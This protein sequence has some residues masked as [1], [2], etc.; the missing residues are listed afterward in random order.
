MSKKL[1]LLVAALF[2]FGC[3]AWAAE[4]NWTGV[5]S[6]DHCQAKHATASDAAA[7]CVAKCVSGG[8]KYVLVVGKKILKVDPQDKFADFAGKRVKVT[9]TLSGDT[10]TATNVEAAAAAMKAAGKA[11]KKA[12]M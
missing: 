2:V 10:V 7:A 12:G 4:G 9:G 11:E 3:M 5:V 1:F 8:G 6:D